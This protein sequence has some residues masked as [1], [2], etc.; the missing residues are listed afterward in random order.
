MTFLTNRKISFRLKFYSALGMAF[1]MCACAGASRPQAGAPRGA[2]EPPYP[3]IVPD[4]PDRASAALAAWATLTQNS[5]SKPELEPVTGTVRGMPPGSSF[6]LPKVTEGPK[7]N[8]EE[9]RESLRRFIGSQTVL[10]GAKLPELSLVLQTNLADDSTRARYEQR[11]FAYPLRGDY[12]ILE[13]TFAQD[14][15]VTQIFSTCIPD[16][17]KYRRA[18]RTLAPAIKTAEDAAKAV[19]GRAFTFTDDA[20]NQQTVTV[21]ANDDVTVRELVVY[22]R[23][24]AGPQ[25]ALELHLAW[26]IAVGRAPSSRLIYLDAV[27]R[28]VVGTARASS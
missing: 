4:N 2:G 1:A 6:Y 27:T 20:G 16:A 18:L 15:R 28:E 24:R 10:V 5:T 22:P 26:E 7:M 3:V 8:D 11:P 17:D 14:R 23:L 19:A 25:N 9:R 12:G 21:G 13:I